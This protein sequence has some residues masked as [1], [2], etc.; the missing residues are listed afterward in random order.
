MNINFFCA[1][2]LLIDRLYPLKDLSS[3]RQQYILHSTIVICSLWVQ[4]ISAVIGAEIGAEMTLMGGVEER[5]GDL[6]S[7]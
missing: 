7:T 6:M 3:S 4:S 5:L 2:S 1:C